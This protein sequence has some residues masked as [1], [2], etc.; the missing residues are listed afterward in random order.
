L[1]QEHRVPYAVDFRDG[2]SID[3]I[4]GTEAFSRDSVR[5][6]WEDRVLAKALAVWCVNEPIAQFYR[7]RYPQLASGVRVV[8]NG[9]DRDSIPARVLTPDPAA[10]LTFGYLGSVNFPAAFLRSVLAGWRLAREADPVL[11]RS[12]FEVR[13]H[14]G[15]GHAREDNDHVELLRAAAADGVT[16]AGPVAKAEVAGTYGRWDALV[17][18]LVG[19]GYVTSGKVYEFMAT[20]LP[21]LSAHEADHDAGNAL[22]GHPL[23]TGA[24]GIDP[25]RLADAFVRAGRMAQEAT[26]AQRATARARADRFAR[27][28]QLVPAVRELTA[29]VG[30]GQR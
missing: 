22:A 17:L 19:G 6:R 4:R 16:F 20:G 1:W 12:T 10:G 28:A 2:W 30:E 5:G 24:V 8:R 11:A 13:G 27:D 29:L 14:I 15:A 25:E 21:V 9:Y 3:V 7:D 18:M 26:E 23:W